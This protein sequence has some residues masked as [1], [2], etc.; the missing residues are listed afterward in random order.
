MTGARTKCEFAA[1]ATND[2]FRHIA[3]ADRK[4]TPF[5]TKASKSDRY[6]IFFVQVQRN[7]SQ[8]PASLT[9][10]S[11]TARPT[12]LALTLGTTYPKEI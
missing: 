10:V 11:K 5:A 9:S 1:V 7:W 8:I 6:F 3:T 4:V 2:G 12:A